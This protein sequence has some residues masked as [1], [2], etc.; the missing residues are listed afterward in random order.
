MTYDFV[1]SVAP[2]KGVFNSEEHSLTSGSFVKMDMT[3][4]D[5]QAVLWLEHLHGMTMNLMWR[6]GRDA[7]G[8]PRFS[9]LDDIETESIGCSCTHPRRMDAYGRV[10]KE[11]N[12]YAKEV[13]ALADQPRPVRIYYSLDS[14]IQDPGH[15]PAIRRAYEGLYSLGVPLGFVTERLLARASLAQRKQYRMIVVA[16]A[17]YMS[18]AAVEDL[19]RCAADGAKVVILG[20]ESLKR[21]AYG[22]PRGPT[23]IPNAILVP[24]PDTMTPEELTPFFEALVEKAG[25]PRTFVCS[26]ASSTDRS[27]AFGVFLRS[28][29]IDGA[30]IVYLLN[31]NPTDKKVCLR[32]EGAPVMRC[33]DL[34]H[35][36]DSVETMTIM[37]KPLERRLLRTAGP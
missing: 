16:G 21:D 23:T 24:C 5:V 31:L 20:S 26:D 30:D 6:W 13:R 7:E 29:P 9:W 18:D 32:R 37:L 25:I 27:S 35:A 1:K 8:A 15:V 11:I 17:T 36:N 4:E 22:R 34:F 28:A 2:N 19:R 10:M 14:Y 12:A 33:Q 3:A